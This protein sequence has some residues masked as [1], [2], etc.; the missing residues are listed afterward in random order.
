MADLL[1]TGVIQE[2]KSHYASPVILVKK[3]DGTWRLCVDYR[4]LSDLTINHN[5]PIPIIDELLDELNGAMYFSKI[6]LWS[7]YFQILMTPE[8][9]HL[10]AF[11]THNTHYEFLVMPFGLCNA[12]ATFQSL[13]N[14]VFR[15]FL[16]KSV[17]V[18][19]DD[20]LIYSSNWDDHMYH[21]STILRLL[22]DNKL[23]AKMSKCVFGQTQLEYLSHIISREGVGTDP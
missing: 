16:R 9:R 8:A 23:Y 13:M 7:G 21:L 14:K 11:R 3:K 17:L 1:N 5:Y 19:F 2:S 4:Y 12:P 15:G 10:M 18:F 6:D 20:I 22:R